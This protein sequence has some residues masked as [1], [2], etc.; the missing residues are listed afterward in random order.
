MIKKLPIEGWVVLIETISGPEL[1][2]RT[3]DSTG[4]WPDIYESERDAQFALIDEME[5]DIQEFKERTR[6]WDEIKWPQDYR[7][8]KITIDRD[9]LMEVWEDSISGDIG[10]TIIATTLTDWRENL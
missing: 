4:I 1:V 6:E 3:E 9:E 8:C 2:W 7:I 10:F 5:D